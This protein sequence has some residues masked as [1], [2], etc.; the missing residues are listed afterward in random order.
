M[1]F[2]ILFIVLIAVIGIAI[3][4]VIMNPAP[5]EECEVDWFCGDWSSCMAG[6]KV[7][8][9]FDKN[10]CG[11]NDTRPPMQEACDIELINE[12]D[13]PNVTIIV[14]CLPLGVVCNEGAECCSGSCL[15]NICRD[16]N[17]YCGDG[18]CDAD[19]DCS[20]CEHDCGECPLNRDL[21]QNVFTKPLGLLKEK[22]YKEDGYVLVRYFY[23]SNCLGCYQPVHIENQLRDLAA[24]FKDLLV[25]VIIDTQVYRDEADRYAKMGGSIYKPLIKIEAF[26]D[27]KAWVTTLYAYTLGQKLLD[28]DIQADVA[29][30]ICKHSDYCDWDGSKIVR[31]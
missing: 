31:V 12:T 8:N 1:T 2:I 6:S 15:E 4:I 9:C 16:V 28:G 7:R 13:E 22:D 23:S 24:N 19:E 17:R 26:Q 21:E 20:D 11:I 10:E 5:P 30:E 27:A 14:D 25:L 3:M 29:E 18:Y